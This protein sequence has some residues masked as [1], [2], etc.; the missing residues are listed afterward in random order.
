MQHK[1]FGNRQSPIACSLERVGEWW[2]IPILADAVCGRARWYAG[3]GQLGAAI[4]SSGQL[5]R[6]GRSEAANLQR[7]P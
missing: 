4:Q 3:P 6:L 7:R 2:S 5:I 1:S